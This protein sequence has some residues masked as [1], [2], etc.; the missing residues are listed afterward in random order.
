MHILQISE[1]RLTSVPL[2][3]YLPLPEVTLR[4]VEAQIGESFE[5]EFTSLLNCLAR[6]HSAI[7]NVR[8][9]LLLLG[10]FSDFLCLSSCR[11]T[12]LARSLV[13]Q[14]D[15]GQFV[16][17]YERSHLVSTFISRGSLADSP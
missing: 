16:L 13:K 9:Q 17:A 3:G 15:L 6:L 7:S 1:F 11:R 2:S 4:S 10:F 8:H 14:L 12:L 5:F